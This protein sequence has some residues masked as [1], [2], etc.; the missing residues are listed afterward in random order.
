MPK[1]LFIVDDDSYFCSHRLHLG[2][3]ART[4]GFEVIVA[5][6]V[7]RH[8]KVI[9][10]EGFRLIPIKLRRGFQNP[11]QDCAALWEL[12]RICRRERPQLV[13]HVALK[14]VL[15]GGIAARLARVPARVHAITGLGHLFHDQSPRTRVLRAVLGPVL[16]WA[17]APPYSTVI[18]QNGED[19]FD[20]LQTGIITESQATIIRGAGVDVREFTPS[21]EPPGIPIAV[22]PARLLR[23]KGVE[24]F[25]AAARILKAQGVRITCALVGGVDPCNPSGLTEAH[26]QQW[27]QEGV[28]ECWGHREDMARVYTAAHVVVLPS[29]HEGLPKVLLEGAASG[30]PLIATRIRGCQEVVR[31]GDNGLLVPVRNAVALAAALKTLAEDAALRQRMGARSREIA[32]HEFS[33][34]RIADE[35]L[36]LYRRL[37]AGLPPEAR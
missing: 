19:R 6:R 35:T 24:E 15:F 34:E 37:G 33:Q 22:L 30:R 11:L 10:D 13:H 8:G 16:R 3:A 29:Y 12:V 1:L 14:M 2:R 17:V 31:D 5:T 21:P 9:E 20:L 7:E 25:V 32:L 27:M 18:V 26:L 23:D 4:A 36:A 28:V